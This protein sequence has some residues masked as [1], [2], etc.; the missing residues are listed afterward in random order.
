MAATRL[1]ASVA[2]RVK[3]ISSCEPALKKAR[4]LS[5]ARLEGLRRGI[6]EIMQAAMH[7]GVF[8]LIGVGHALDHLPRLLRR[9]GIVEIDERL[10]VDLRSTG[11]GNRA[12]IASTS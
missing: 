10:A 3:T 1:I 9:G 8:V 11:S 4:T 5:R 12:R 6:G 7:I 2:E